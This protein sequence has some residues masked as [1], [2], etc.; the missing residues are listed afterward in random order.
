MLKTF[1]LVFIFA[2]IQ[3]AWYDPLAK[4]SIEGYLTQNEI[5]EFLYDIGSEQGMKTL[6][7]GKNAQGNEILGYYVESCK[8]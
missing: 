2:V 6:N 3:G 4:G 8:I 1:P 7:L 5:K